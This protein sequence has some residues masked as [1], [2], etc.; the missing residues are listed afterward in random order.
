VNEENHIQ[1]IV[2]G[3][4]V[5]LARG[6]KVADLVQAL[7]LS[8]KRLAIEL[9]LI[10]LPRTKWAETELQTGDKLEVV[11]FVGGG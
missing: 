4:Q 9:N 6:S 2:N 5:D 3:E 7:E 1:I 8:E 10:I 11:H